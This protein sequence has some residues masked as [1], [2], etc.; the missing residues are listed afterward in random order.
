MCLESAFVIFP[1]Q[2]KV[3]EGAIK[4]VARGSAVVLFVFSG[5]C[6]QCIASEVSLVGGFCLF[7]FAVDLCECQ[8]ALDT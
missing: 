3:L 5:M 4:I 1:R 6:I 2:L 8:R 7:A